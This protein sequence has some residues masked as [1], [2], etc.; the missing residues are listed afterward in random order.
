MVNSSFHRSPALHKHEYNDERRRRRRR[1]E[2]RGEERREKKRR[3][4]DTEQVDMAN[5]GPK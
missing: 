2:R 3:D 5:L 1:R 4:K